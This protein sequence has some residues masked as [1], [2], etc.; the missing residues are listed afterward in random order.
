MP[1]SPTPKR[2]PLQNQ[3]LQILLIGILAGL[4]T[5]LILT[6]FT[7]L[8]FS[9]RAVAAG[10]Q[11]M[12]ELLANRS[13]AALIFN[14][15]KAINDNLKSVNSS[16]TVLRIC[17]YDS[18]NNQFGTY[19]ARSS[20]LGN[21]QPTYQP[22]TRKSGYR[23]INDTLQVAINI[24][25]DTDSYGYLVID[26]NLNNV[27][28]QM[29]Q[30]FYILISAFLV[31]IFLAY[32]L[33]RRLLKKAL[34]PLGQLHNETLKIT[35]GNF[36]NIEITVNTGKRENEVSD[37]VRSYQKMLS[38]LKQ[39]HQRLKKSEDRFRS[40]TD[41][42][43]V[44][45][46]FKEVANGSFSY[47]NARWS[48]LTGIHQNFAGTKYINFIHPEDRP[49]YQ[50]ALIEVASTGEAT[51]LEY[52]FFSPNC[53]SPK[54]LMEY[55]SPITTHPNERT[56][57]GLIGSVLDISELKSAQAELEYL[58]FYDA[59]TSLP[60]RRFFRDH[61]DSR[62]AAAHK[63]GGSLSVLMIDLDNFKSVNDLMGHDAGDLLLQKVGSLLR[64][65][66]FTEDVVARLGG[67]EFIILIEH[68][69]DSHNIDHVLQKLLAIIETPILI[70]NTPVDVTCSIGVAS[71]PN[72]A[73]NSQDLVH[74]ADMAMYQAKFKGKNQVDFF[75]AQL[76]KNI[77]DKIRLERK[78]RH[79][80]QNN[81][82]EI[83][84]QPQFDLRK[85]R[86]YW[87]EAL[88]RWHDKDEGYISPERF[89]AL[90][91]ETGLIVEV[92]QWVIRQ[93]CQLLSVYSEGLSA[94]GIAGLSINL[95]GQEFYHKDLINYLKLQLKEFQI[96]PDCLEFEL[97]ESMVI[98]DIDRAIQ[99][100]Q[101]L[102]DLGCYLSLDDFGTG[103]SSLSYLKK[104]NIDQLKIDKSFVDGLPGDK[105]DEAI[106][107]AILAMASKL[108]L[109]V[110]AEGIESQ[111]QSQYLFN[112]G[113]YLMQ[114]YYYAKPMP[115]EELLSQSNNSPF[116]GIQDR[117]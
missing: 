90:A 107:G 24:H 81:G 7:Q 23:F 14:D 9:K 62:I 32:Q 78:L 21:C 8:Y 77:Q 29:R 44:G 27:H 17:V 42:S 54:V 97:T 4:L 76:N 75:S 100:M 80:L 22:E 57:V 86:F 30:N 109:V 114:G 69:N 84:I 50:Q 68:S 25:D 19:Y 112:R 11:Q 43:P 45:I 59:L 39:E 12:G 31:S 93:V 58:A 1:E 52:R 73:D 101:E 70:N 55:I 95:S 36:Q 96:Q 88:I 111:E 71:F 56:D 113:C 37:L 102:Q 15:P 108:D 53:E 67:D 72:D 10:L 47:V 34:K 110:I 89:I 13:I 104:F 2:R 63:E 3:L 85:D 38:T 64:S 83:Y 41:N 65:Q 116:D 99:T 79:A 18:N 117:H 28:A 33:S 98:E 82:L 74:H 94:I 20:K 87:G 48:H 40:L 51:A 5:T 103:Y 91:E 16:N 106:T 35:E 115:I 26:G 49:T 66:V 46:Y 92:G 60:N 61:L 105:N 6:Q